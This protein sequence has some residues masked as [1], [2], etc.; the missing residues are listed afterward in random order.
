ML[1]QQFERE[2]KRITLR[3]NFNKPVCGLIY[4]D[5]NLHLLI[6]ETLNLPW[7]FYSILTI[8]WTDC[9]RCATALIFD[10]NEYARQIGKFVILSDNIWTK[11]WFFWMYY[12]LWKQYRIV[13]WIKSE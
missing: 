7:F 9:W 2:Q 11:I 12:K 6:W 8:F 1:H 13:H 10:Q 3:I 5:D 4:D